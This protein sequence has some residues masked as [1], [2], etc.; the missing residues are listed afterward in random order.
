MRGDL[1]FC[2][3]LLIVVNKM[4]IASVSWE[5]SNNAD[6]A[7]DDD[8]GDNDDAHDDEARMVMLSRCRV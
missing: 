8:G 5:V 4:D 3:S 1:D 7:D 6:G 2:S